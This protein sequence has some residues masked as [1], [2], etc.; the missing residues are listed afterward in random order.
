MP[1]WRGSPWKSLVV[2]TIAWERPTR[3]LLEAILLRRPV[4][5]RLQS[6][7][8]KTMRNS[9]RHCALVVIAAVGVTSFSTG[10]RSGG[11]NM[12]GSSWVSWGKKKPP[13]SSIAGTREPTQPPSVGVPPYP[14]DDS[15]SSSATSTAMASYPSTSPPG[16]KPSA[17]GL[18]PAR[19]ER[20]QW[21]SAERRGHQ[22]VRHRT[23]WHGRQGLARPQT[24]QGF[25]RTSPP[26]SGGPIASTA[27]RGEGIPRRM[28]PSYSSGESPPRV[29]QLPQQRCDPECRTCALPRGNQSPVTTPVT[30][31]AT[32]EYGTADS[33]YPAPVA[34]GGIRLP[35]SANPNCR[36][37]QLS[38]RELGP[39]CSGSANGAYPATRRPS[40]LRCRAISG[41][42]LKVPRRVISLR[43]R[44]VL[45]YVWDGGAAASSYGTGAT[46]ERPRALPRE[47]RAHRVDIGREAP[48]AITP[49]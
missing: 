31:Y 15:S 22:R 23:V 42:A 45:R 41:R 8:W 26:D 7:V 12:P 11:W 28:T 44:V 13:T 10:C 2:S 27:T 49:T 6:K 46:M 9:L 48:A 36:R 17:Y 33:G 29:I 30:G 19:I 25:Y 24:Q 40:H 18:V 32:P 21:R 1:E 34:N 38:G 35:D 43:R 4:T 3:R 37:Q 5:P 39:G 14:P 47:Q 16:D 20:H